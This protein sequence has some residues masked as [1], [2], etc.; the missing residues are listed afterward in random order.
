MTAAFAATA[1]L[2]LTAPVNA[3]ANPPAPATGGIVWNGT[4]DRSIA[5]NIDAQP[6]ARTDASGIKI[7]SNA[8][9]ADIP[10][11]YFIWDSKQKDVGYLKVDA[12]V[13]DDFD[14]FVLTTKESNTYWD[15][16]I[17][18]QP[19]QLKTADGCY[20]FYI[21]KVGA[22]AKNINMVF[23]DGWTS[24]A[25]PTLHDS[26]SLGFIGYYVYGDTGIVMSTSIYWVTLDK[27]G[28]CVNWDDV[29]AAY[30]AWAANEG[31][32]A[33]PGKGYQS[34][35]ANPM[36][37]GPHDAICYGTMGPDQMEGYY[38]SYYVDP[39]Y[40]LAS[41]P[42]LVSFD[43]YVADVHLW[44]DL[45][46]SNGDM[47]GVTTPDENTTLATEGGAAH[48]YALLAYAGTDSLPSYYRFGWGQKVV[49]D[50][51]ADALEV[52]LLDVMSNHPDVFTDNPQAWLNNYQ[53]TFDV[54]LYPNLTV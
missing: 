7:S 9:S 49:Y 5:A 33:N 14:G 6:S 15:F 40:D 30:A 20:V 19:G 28:D 8:Q 36:S 29:N 25:A 26:W 43:R 2:A 12:K 37:F 52:G 38:Y 42:V 16:Q 13:F 44:N 11:I 10:G 31:N 41:Y 35:G 27:P 24:K 53:Q 34:S 17:A 23:F 50:Q 46:T 1:A 18:L 54:S 21:P 22:D 48:Y 3:N 51:W 39:G 32:L 4:T 47:A 45:Y